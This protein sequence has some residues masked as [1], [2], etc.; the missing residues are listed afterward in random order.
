MGQD[1]LANTDRGGRVVLNKLKTVF[2][3]NH[4]NEIKEEPLHELPLVRPFS[5][6]ETETAPAQIHRP[7]HL[8]M[9]INHAGHMRIV[10]KNDEDAARV[11]S[12]ALK[13]TRD[14]KTVIYGEDTISAYLSDFPYLKLLTLTKNSDAQCTFPFFNIGKP[15]EVRITEITQCENGCEGQLEVYTKGSALTFFDT[16]YF[17]N[18]NTYFPGKDSNVLISG[19]AYVL[20][21]VKGAP[22]GDKKLKV[23]EATDSDLAF[24]YENGDVDDYVFRG[25]IEEVREFTVLDK[26]AQAIKVPLRIGVDTVIDI[27]V[28]ATENAIREKLQKGDYVSGIVWLQGFVVE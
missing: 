10:A 27:Y 14:K 19:I 11:G 12:E 16:L 6:M 15:I 26:K 9:N 17:K 25:K 20:T 13:L 21:K 2:G 4:I 23:Q 8:K 5:N 3:G 7:D 22:V 28:C 24:R 1:I 18:K